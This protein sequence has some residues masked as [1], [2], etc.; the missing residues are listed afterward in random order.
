VTT[1]SIGI[2]FQLVNERARVLRNSPT[3]AERKLWYRL[4]DLKVLGQKF[5][6]QVPIDHFIVDFACLS[7]RLIVE[8]DGATHVTEA[9]IASDMRR[10]RYLESQGFVV[11]RFSNM[12]VATNVDGLM[13]SVL[14]ALN[15]LAREATPT[16]DPFPQWEGELPPVFLK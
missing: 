1:R 14:G 5:R 12:D 8:F 7:H 6:R 2:E 15:A 4:R 9:E 3:A 13:E 10:Q 16:P 11:L